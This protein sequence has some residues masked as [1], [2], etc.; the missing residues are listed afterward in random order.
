MARESSNSLAT[1]NQQVNIN[2]NYIASNSHEIA[3]EQT[4]SVEEIQQIVT[5]ANDKAVIPEHFPS[6]S[7]LGNQGNEQH[8]DSMDH[9][10]VTFMQR[11]QRV[12][13]FLWRKDLTIGKLLSDGSE[14]LSYDVPALGLTQMILNKLDGI[15][16]F[17]ATAVVRLQLNS[18]PFQQGRLI[19]AAIPM[20]FLIGQ[21][22]N[23]L[24][25][26]PSLLQSVNHVQVDIS[27]QTEV[28]LRVPFV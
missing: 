15:T 21:R 19:L 22:T 17:R 5:F 11:P 12:K 7:I 18:Q 20:P 13:S 26:H 8:S 2:S 27:K 24:M 10:I 6:E 16:S 1:N 14:V 3:P 4:N 25:K 23:W 9:T 28:T